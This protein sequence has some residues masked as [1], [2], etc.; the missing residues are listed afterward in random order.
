MTLQ[1]ESGFHHTCFLECLLITLPNVIHASVVCQ[2]KA[3]LSDL[4]VYKSDLRNGKPLSQNKGTGYSVLYR[5]RTQGRRRGQGS[6]KKGDKLNPRNTPKR[7]AMGSKIQYK[8]SRC[9]QHYIE[10][11]LKP[12]VRDLGSSLCSVPKKHCGLGKIMPAH[13]L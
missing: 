12:G 3:S 11:A 8:R 2:W 5:V 13:H 7:E 10:L 4:F 9:L 1:M 6:R